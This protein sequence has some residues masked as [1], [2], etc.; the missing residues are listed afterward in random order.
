[1]TRYVLLA[2]SFAVLASLVAHCRYSVRTFKREVLGLRETYDDQH[3]GGTRWRFITYPNDTDGSYI[4]VETLQRPGVAGALPGKSGSPPFH[5]HMKQRECFVVNKGVFGHIGNGKETTLF[6]N[7]T[8]NKPF[9]VAPGVSHTFWNADNTSEMMITWTLEPPLHAI[10]FFRTYIGLSR[11]FGSV[12]NV[13]PLQLMVSFTYGD[14][15]LTG[16]PR[17]FWYLVEKVLVP[18]SCHVLGFQPTYTE[19]VIF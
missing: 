7:D 6:P 8:L 18:F 11:D 4:K 2:T 1:M 15:S 9:C 14:L 10:E 12:S 3:S 16:M 5:A 17:P 13:N 19:Y